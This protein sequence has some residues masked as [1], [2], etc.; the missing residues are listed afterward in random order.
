MS[1]TTRYKKWHSYALREAKKI[2]GRSEVIAVC[3]DGSVQFKG[4][5]YLSNKKAVQ[6]YCGDPGE[7]YDC[8][9]WI[10]S[11]DGE[12]FYIKYSWGEISPILRCSCCANDYWHRYDILERET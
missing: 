11:G 12:I 1:P 2:F 3:E 7:C 4:S 5:F 9:T 6:P 10:K 8:Q